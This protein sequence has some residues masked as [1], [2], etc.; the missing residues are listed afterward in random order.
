MSSVRGV[1]KV[2]HVT[3][4]AISDGA[5]LRYHVEGAADAHRVIESEEHRGVNFTH[6]AKIPHHK[7]AGGD[8][9]EEV[10]GSDL[11]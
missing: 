5:A 6:E 1:L 10:M 9:L 2:E 8:I 7:E 3:R 4:I 11:V